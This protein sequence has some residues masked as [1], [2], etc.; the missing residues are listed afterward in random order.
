MYEKHKKAAEWYAD[1]ALGWPTAKAIDSKHDRLVPDGVLVLMEVEGV[2]R[3]AMLLHEH[4][5]VVAQDSLDEDDFKKGT[6][7]A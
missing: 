5:A 3:W 6:A 7:R 1:V 2:E 4:T